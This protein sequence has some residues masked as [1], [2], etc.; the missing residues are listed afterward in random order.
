MSMEQPECEAEQDEADFL[1]VGAHLADSLA[2]GPGPAQAVSTAV[3]G[4]GHD[5]S[6]DSGP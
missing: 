3:G 4:S 2:E 1:G 6:V 5:P